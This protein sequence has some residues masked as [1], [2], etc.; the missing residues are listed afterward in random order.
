MCGIA[1]FISLLKPDVGDLE[2]MLMMLSHRGPDEFGTF[3]NS[4][5]ALGSARL[6]I[7]DIEGGQQP[8]TDEKAQVTIVFNGEIYNYIELREELKKQGVRFTGNSDTEVILRSYLCHGEDFCRNLN[9]EFAIAIWDERTKKLVL[10]RDRIGIRPL[11]YYQDRGRFIFSSEMKAILIHPNIPRR[12][13]L[14]ALD[15]IFTFWT[16]IEQNTLL[17]DIKALP[18]GHLL[19]HQ[20]GRSQIRNFWK[21]PFPSLSAKRTGSFEDQ[22]DECLSEL[23]KAVRYRMRADVEVGSYL[24]GGIDS[25]MIVALST[26]QSG[27]NLRTFS[28]AFKEKSYDER[29]YQQ[30]VSRLFDTKHEMIECDYDDIEKIFKDIVWHAETAVFRTAP[31]PL[32]MLS[33]LVRQRNIKVVLTGEGA[34]EILLGYDLYRQVKIRKFWGRR[35]D[36]KFRWQLFRKLY[37][38]LPQFSDK[39]YAQVAIQSFKTDLTSDSPFYSHLIR[40]YNNAANRVY[41]SKRVQQDLSGYDAY[42]DLKDHLPVEHFKS[43]EID[44]AQYLDVITLLRGYLLS[45]QGDRMSMAHSVEGRYP[46]LDHQFVEYASTIPEKYK[47]MRLKDKRILREAA[48]KFLPKDICQRP[49]MAYQAPEIRPFITKEGR[50]SDLVSHY[51]AQKCIK[52]F[53]LFEPDM[54]E[55]LLNKIRTSDQTRL[56]MRDNTAFV[57]MLS[58]Q[59]FVDLF[60]K[61]NIRELAQKK[62]QMNTIKFTKR[63]GEIAGTRV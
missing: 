26:A 46:F 58:A 16:P 53:D 3:V 11:F 52:D 21:W 17:E 9:G 27:A 30:Q 12:L 62:R 59:I 2:L 38:Y 10:A 7:I 47:L 43:N 1:G 44:Q 23:N 20:N 18:P 13:N 48:L 28:V 4:Q 60:I 41:F 35:P 29:I 49:K 15:Q 55:S 39:R 22:R 40:W 36:S 32:F 45:S 24:S 5:A 54:V 61:Q 57:E 51:L 25:S 56:G 31:S 63:L 33:Q 50:V 34:D 37:S 6:A 42:Q 19:I 14:K 8:I